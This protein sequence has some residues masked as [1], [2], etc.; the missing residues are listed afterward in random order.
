MNEVEFFLLRHVEFV[1][2][3]TF[4]GRKIASMEPAEFA[5]QNF[6]LYY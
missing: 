5:N 6:N 2:R 3:T 1:R 4:S